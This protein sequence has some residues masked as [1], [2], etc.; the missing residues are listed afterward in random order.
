MALGL[1]SGRCAIVWFEHGSVATATIRDQRLRSHYLQ[2]AGTCHLSPFLCR[3]RMLFLPIISALSFSPATKH[4]SLWAWHG[5]SAS[6]VTGRMC[7]RALTPPTPRMTHLHGTG[8]YA[9]LSVRTARRRFSGQRWDA[10]LPTSGDGHVRSHLFVGWFAAA[11][12]QHAIAASPSRAWTS[13]RGW[14]RYLIHSMLPT[15]HP[16][17][18]HPPY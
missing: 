4:C 12:T 11:A 9:T 13:A 3:N 8:K 5:T 16:A 1:C 7:T 2:N 10:R 17:L 18:Y 6:L 14:R 15:T